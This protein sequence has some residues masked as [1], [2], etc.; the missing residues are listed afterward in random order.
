MYLPIY[1]F[2]PPTLEK[3]SLHY[4]CHEQVY[5][6]VE[7]ILSN[8]EAYSI[9][10]ETE[11]EEPRNHLKKLHLPFL[12]NDRFIANRSAPKDQKKS[13]VKSTSIFSDLMDGKASLFTK[14]PASQRDVDH[15]ESI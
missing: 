8:P 5:K 4:S 3:S 12:R 1:N 2:I 15:S 9:P 6:T 10:E 14:K 13:V 11:S 7:T